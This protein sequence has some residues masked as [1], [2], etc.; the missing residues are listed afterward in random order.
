MSGLPKLALRVATGGGGAAIRVSV[1]GVPLVIDDD[2]RGIKTVA[3]INEWLEPGRNEVRLDLEWPWDGAVRGRTE[4]EATVGLLEGN[5]KPLVALRCPRP[6]PLV[7]RWPA[8]ISACFE[9]P[10]DARARVFAEA[11]RIEAVDYDARAGA[12]AAVRALHD[13]LAAG[14]AERAV[15]LCDYRT[16]DKAA[17]YGVDPGRERATVREIYGKLVA[18]PGW[19]LLP[20]EEA[21][22]Q[23][24]LLAGGRLVWVTRFR[25]EPVLCTAPGLGFRVRMPVY[26]ARIGG[27]WT[28][29]R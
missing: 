3:P 18:S 17:A 29:A 4:V 14:D 8:S 10:I 11:E 16:R 21:P 13:A 5:A 24:H 12:L 2:A 6:S 7:R 15:S 27:A 1:G 9:A 26:V 23:T 25:A 28:I 19:K 20:W 22:L